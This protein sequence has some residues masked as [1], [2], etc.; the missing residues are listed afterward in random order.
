MNLF[1]FLVDSLFACLC[2]VLAI[3]LVLRMKKFVGLTSSG[4]LQLRSVT[5][6]IGLLLVR[7]R[8]FENT[9]LRQ[10]ALVLKQK[11]FG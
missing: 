1:Q 4:M 10:L 8:G 3:N 2:Y 11:L 7:C 9:E 6:F 5:I